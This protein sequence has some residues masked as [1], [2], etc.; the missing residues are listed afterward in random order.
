MNNLNNIFRLSS[1]AKS[2]IGKGRFSSIR[3][4]RWEIEFPKNG[5]FKMSN[6]TTGHSKMLPVR[7][8]KGFDLKKRRL[9][10][11]CNIGLSEHRVHFLKRWRKLYW[12][13]G[14]G[15]HLLSECIEIL[16]RLDPV[17]LKTV[18]TIL[19]SF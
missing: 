2:H 18:K 3:D 10:L 15:V 7:L 5:L 11:D 6:L 13:V 17:K 14:N 8:I 1:P 12:H 19:M 4:D 9:L 16:K